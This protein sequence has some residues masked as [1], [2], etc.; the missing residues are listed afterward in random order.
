MNED[1][2]DAHSAPFFSMV[3]APTRPRPTNVSDGLWYTLAKLEISPRSSSSKAG[4]TVVCGKDIGGR[5]ASTT[6]CQQKNEVVNYTTERHGLTLAAP[7]SVDNSRQYMYARSRT[8]GES[9]SFVAVLRTRCTIPWDESG[10]C[11]KS[12]TTAVNVCN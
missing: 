7:G 3:S 2:R 11:K 12:F 10:F 5:R 9:Q 6:A 1:R 4:D 8:S